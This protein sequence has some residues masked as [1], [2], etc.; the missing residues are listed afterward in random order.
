VRATVLDG[1][2]G[3]ALLARGLPA[4]ALPEEWLL[5]RPDEIGRVHAAH[6]AAGAEL[7][8]TCTFNLAAP[9]LSS[10]LPCFDAGALAR[11]AVAL[12]REAAPSARVAGA[13][14]PTGLFGPGRA[15]PPL[16]ELRARYADAAGALIDGGADLIWL[17]SQ[18]DLAEARAALAA[19]RTGGR[20]VAVTFTALLDGAPRLPD[21]VPLLDALAAVAADGAAIVGVN[22]VAAG[23]PLAALAQAAAARVAVPFA[24]KPSPGLPGE[25]LPPERFAAMLAP[26]LRAGAAYAGGCCGATADHVRALAAAVRAQGPLRG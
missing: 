4:G 21:G 9:R 22:C 20:E 11:V 15:A 14:G 16:G 1:A 2:M 18:W 25:I 13:L 12:A 5:A 6:A 7:V 8:L 3:T 19:V 24:A 23:P 26:V 17:E 10:R